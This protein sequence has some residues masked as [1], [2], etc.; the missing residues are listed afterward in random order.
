MSDA[1]NSMFGEE[2]KEYSELWKKADNV[3][4]QLFEDQLKEER[5]EIE[6]YLNNFGKLR[7][8]VDAFDKTESEKMQETMKAISKIDTLIAFLINK[9]EQEHGKEI[10]KLKK[11]SE[12]L[13]KELMSACSETTFSYFDSGPEVG[14][15]VHSEEEWEE[16]ME[17][18]DEFLKDFDG[19]YKKF[20]KI[21]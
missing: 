16:T 10:A 18:H 14:N 7:S 20:K 5:K 15:S 4:E 9:D 6:D 19:N 13:N 8:S 12:K 17:T 3:F 2:E 11:I 1:L 21:D